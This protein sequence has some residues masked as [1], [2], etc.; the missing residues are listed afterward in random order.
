[1]VETRRKCRLASALLVSMAV[2]FFSAGSP[3]AHAQ[4]SAGCANLLASSFC[5]GNS[6]WKIAEIPYPSTTYFANKSARLTGELKVGL[7]NGISLKDLLAS[8][9]SAMDKDSRFS[10]PP[11]LFDETET[12]IVGQRG[13][14][15]IWQLHTG[16]KKPFLVVTCALRD[17]FSLCVTTFHKNSRFDKAELDL[18]KALVTSLTY[19]PS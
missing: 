19:R 13:V 2:S 14:R 4:A 12:E 5:P 18:H 6:G 8:H 3:P 17:S 16:K 10:A 15:R 9:Q 7:N 11:R 1:M